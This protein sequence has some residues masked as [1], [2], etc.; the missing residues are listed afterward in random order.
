[1]E[2]QEIIMRGYENRSDVLFLYVSPESFVPKDHPLRPIRLM[3]DKALSSLSPEFGQMY[4]HTG[5]PSVPPEVLLKSLLLQI[6]FS[7]RSNRLLVEQ[8]GYNIL[9][10]WFL[11]LSLEEKIWDH[12]TFSQN[13]ERL[14]GTDI[15]GQFLQKIIAQA[16]EARL[17]SKDHFSVDGTLIEAWASIKSFHPRDGGP[18]DRSG[19]N[20]EV[21]FHEKRLKNDTHASTTD[22]E[23]RL[24]RKGKGKESKLCY[25][26]HALMENRNGLV[27]DVCLTPATGTA[28]RDAAAEM[29]KNIPGMRRVTVGAD[30][31]YD[32][33]GFVATL[34]SMDATP[35][36]AQNDTNRR[37][38]IDNRTTRHPG[39]AVSSKVRKRIEEIFGW[40]KTV[41]VLR[42]TRYRGTEKTSWYFTLA[43]AAYD[44]IRMRNLG[45]GTT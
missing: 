38:A 26:G 22:P 31:G 18:K 19:R 10:R 3:A 12:S 13:Q 30:K 36:V 11:G 33:A 20:D 32:T 39:Y 21:D 29:V 7:I 45:V 4:S 43:V 42:K 6:L 44:L 1:L 40:I 17:L 37:S 8:L 34:R 16:T 2:L 9:F 15:A 24:Y 35:H 14:I 25:I 23:S 41:G 27:V 28:E 5:R